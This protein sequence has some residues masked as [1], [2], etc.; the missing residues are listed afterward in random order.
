M[1]VAA[2]IHLPVKSRQ[3][4]NPVGATQIARRERPSTERG[5][6]KSLLCNSA[7]RSRLRGGPTFF[8]SLSYQGWPNMVVATG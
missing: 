5:Q 8:S 1:S 2:K 6:T 4:R 7:V 3:P